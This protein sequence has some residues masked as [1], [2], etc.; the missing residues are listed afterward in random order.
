MW[1]HMSKKLF[2]YNYYQSQV[3]ACLS[4][5]ENIPK[6]F[7]VED[8]HQLRVRIKKIKAIFQ[9][10][11]YSGSDLVNSK[12]FYRL[13]RSVFRKAGFI[14][15][16]QVNISLIKSFD[17][18]N[19]LVD[20]FE[21]Y[22]IIKEEDERSALIKLIKKFNYDRSAEQDKIVKS[23]FTETKRES[24][25][26]L[27]NAFIQDKVETISS[28]PRPKGDTRIIHEIRIQLKSI[29]PILTVLVN[30]DGSGYTVSAYNDLDIVEK[31]IGDWHDLFVLSISLARF[32]NYSP[33]TGNDILDVYIKL[34]KEI[35]ADTPLSIES[36]YQ[37]LTHLLNELREQSQV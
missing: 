19:Y 11:E 2:L 10:I 3:K 9:L 33:S 16:N 37:N 17:G 24:L 20:E 36:I 1:S 28:L 35:K 13:F 23:F 31:Q 12:E 15:E 26:K 32:I 4:Y 30:I 5:M 7:D 25:I 6:S 22:I 14:R 27:S 18:Y 8:I 21:K 34:I 29:K